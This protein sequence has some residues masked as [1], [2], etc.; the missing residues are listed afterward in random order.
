[1]ELLYQGTVCL[2]DATFVISGACLLRRS[3]K[4]ESYR[5]AKIST[6]SESQWNKS[7]FFRSL[8][9][10]WRLIAFSFLY[11]TSFFPYLSNPVCSLKETR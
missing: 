7:E 1:M 3:F 5:L 8:S 10:L 2:S 4:V 11:F 6:S 9:K